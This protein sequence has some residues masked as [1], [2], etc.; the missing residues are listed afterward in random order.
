[1][2]QG[3][4]LLEGSASGYQPLGAFGQPVHQSYVQLRAAIERKLGP[5]YAN[6]F[7]RPQT[8]ERS[9]TIRWVAP[10]AGKAVSWRDLSPAEQADRALDLQIMRAEFERYRQELLRE[11]TPS[12]NGRPSG[13]QAFAAV[14]EQ[15]L[16][17]P[18]D[19]HLHFVDDQP[20]ATFWGFSEPGQKPFEPLGLAPA[21]ARSTEPPPASPEPPLVPPVAEPTR[22]RWWSWLLWPLLLLLLL[23]L[24]LFLFWPRDTEIAGWKPPVTLQSVLHPKEPERSFRTIDGRIVKE[25]GGLFYDTNGRLVDRGQVVLDGNAAG[26]SADK[27]AV[28]PGSAPSGDD[29]KG[30]R[31]PSPKDAGEKGDGQQPTTPKPDA[32]TQDQ[33]NGQQ[34][35]Q[36]KQDQ[37]GAGT[38]P[39]PATQPPKPETGQ[40]GSPPD[41]TKP[42]EDANAPAGPPLSIPSDAAAGAGTGPADF[43]AGQWRSQSGLVDQ[44][45]GAKLNQTYQFDKSGN[46]RSVVRRSNGMEC[47]AP[48]RALMENGKLQVQELDNLR[49]P[50]G[51]AF[52][53]STTTCTRDASGQTACMGANA[54]GTGYEVKIDRAR[55]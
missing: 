44:D 49:C 15:A 7:A 55:P 37:N 8:D 4:I 20:V 29:A 19:A 27:G 31:A 35:K 6:F 9:Q 13:G 32:K 1:M 2:R 3:D 11:A 34:D 46:G 23:L 24:L 50:D 52:E 42:G 36:D 45:T 41:G 48:A 28:T 21:A 38:P 26:T 51:Q 43:L 22:R 5:R 12:A 54:G 33:P 53:K 30:D 16:K 40:N 25:R 14:L 10:I 18:N 17:T 39:N 47:S